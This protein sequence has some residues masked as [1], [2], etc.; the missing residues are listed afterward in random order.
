MESKMDYI[1]LGSTPFDEECVQVDSSNYTNMSALESRAYIT[2]LQRQ[3]SGEIPEGCYF[4]AKRFPH[5][6]GSYREVCVFFD[7]DDESHVRFAVRAE[8]ESPARW[9]KES[10]E[11][12]TENGYNI[13]K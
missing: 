4:R 8:N 11:Y 12:L 13:A 3:F 6:F 1:S 9:D 7:S 10:W 5:D 2:Q